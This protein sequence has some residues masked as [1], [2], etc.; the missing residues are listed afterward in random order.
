MS[1]AGESSIRNSGKGSVTGVGVGPGD[2]ELL[3]VKAVRLLQ[4]ADVIAFHSAKHGQSIAR[5]A[6]EPYLRGDQIEELLVYPLTT[7]STGHP[8][9]YAGAMED[10]YVEATATLAA[11]LDAGRNVV[12]AC[13]G[14]PGFF[15]SYQHLHDRLVVDYDAT[16]VPGISS[17]SASAAAAGKPAVMN[18]QSLVVIPGT[19]PEPEITARIS[20]SEAVA[21]LKLGR[22]FEKVRRALRAA[23]KDEQAIYVE[24]VSS[25]KQRVLPLNDVDA[26]SVPYMSLILVP[27]VVRPE[28]GPDVPGNGYVAVVGL[29]PGRSERLTAEAARELAQATDIVGYTPYV[30]RVPVR[31]GQRRHPSDNR[32]ENERALM[33]VEMAERGRRVAVVSSGD[34]GIFAMAAAVAEE[35]KGHGVD[36][37][38]VPG[39]TAAQAVAAKVGAPLGHDFCI[40]S[41]S[42]YLKPQDIIEKRL[43]AAAIADLVIGL[44][45]PASKTRRDEV[46]LAK[47]VLL[48]HRAPDTPV[49]IARDVD[50]AQE[51][52]RVVKLAELDVDEVDMRTLLLIGSS[53]TE[54]WVDA[55]GNDKVLSPRRYPG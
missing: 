50:G 42:T 4:E 52:V 18:E 41:L 6:I 37:R 22:T 2:P 40:L 45:N 48:R 20:G 43:E 3:T 14:D 5:K 15:G 24:R 54:H 33:A 8:G 51:S 17:L 10:F 29:G 7:E 21:V 39:V 9:G 13:E 36:V 26:D 55:Q 53:Q 23:G 46:A 35:A 27:G 49:V 30:D 34:P 19:L 31:R 38:I 16:I 11:H 32:V 28:P 12:V 1:S 47:E 44:Y 25:D